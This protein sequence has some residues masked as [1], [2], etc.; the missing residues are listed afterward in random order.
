MIT[1]LKYH[2]LVFMIAF[3]SQVLATGKSKSDNMNECTNYVL[4]QGSSNVNRFEFINYN[5]SIIKSSNTKKSDNPGQNIKISVNQF[6]GPNNIMLKDFYKMLNATKY[7]FI[8]IEIESR[9]TADFDETTGLTYFQ[10]KITIAE[11]TNNFKIPCQIIYCEK[12]GYLVKGDLALDL[13][14]FNIDPPKKMFGTVKVDDEVF[15][16]FSFHYL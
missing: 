11:I 1:V 2:L 12:S 13:S 16:T 9:E 8:N 6:S 7:P 10:T 5:P 3:W 4:I 14:N 15:I